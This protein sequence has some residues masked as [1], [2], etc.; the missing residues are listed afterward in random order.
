MKPI[1]VKENTYTDSFKEINDE[2]AKFKLVVILEYQNT[3]WYIQNW[4][5]EVLKIKKVKNVVGHVSN[6]LNGEE[7]IGTSYEKELQKTNQN[8][9]E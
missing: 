5:E 2:D 3:K 8:N 4:S 7:I 1:D 9:L 6:D